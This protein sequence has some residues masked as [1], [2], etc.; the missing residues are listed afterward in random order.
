MAVAKLVFDGDGAWVFFTGDRFKAAIN[1]LPREH[2]EAILT[3]CTQDVGQLCISARSIDELPLME[4]SVML[5]HVV[6][7]SGITDAGK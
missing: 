7:I 6:I 4:W 2:L 3:C 1:I 5:L